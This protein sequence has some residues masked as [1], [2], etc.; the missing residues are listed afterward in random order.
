MHLIRELWFIRTQIG[1]ILLTKSVTGYRIEINDKEI[2]IHAVEYFHE[3]QQLLRVFHT[4]IEIE[5]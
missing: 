4:E 1:K 5:L 3:L 2:P